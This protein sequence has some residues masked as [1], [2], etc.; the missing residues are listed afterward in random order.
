[1]CCAA[2]SLALSRRFLTVEDVDHI[3]MLVKKFLDQYIVVVD[4]GAGSGTTALSVFAERQDNIAVITVDIDAAAIDWAAL[5]V[6]N[7]GLEGKWLG[8]LADSKFLSKLKPDMVLIDGDHTYEGVK[9]D[10]DF[11]I[12]K[13]K[14]G[15][16]VWLHDYLPVEEYPG[17]KKAIEGFSGLEHIKTMGL[18]WSGV[19]L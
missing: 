19:K 17:V 7:I 6:K 3:R 2:H 9:S 1:M 14:K 18:S 4:I 11:W 8:R 15:G 13:L 10:L 16:I 12:P 5:A